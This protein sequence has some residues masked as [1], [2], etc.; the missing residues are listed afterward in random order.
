MKNNLDQQIIM[1]E[2]RNLISFSCKSPG[3]QNTGFENLHCA[4]LKKHFNAKDVRID[5]VDKTINLN[6]YVEHAVKK[7]K[8]INVDMKFKD[9]NTFLLG[10]LDQENQDIMFYKNILNFYS[11]NKVVEV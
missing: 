8:Y 6:M 3:E 7:S 5:Y 4:I 9:I 10:C 1:N 2:M 11:I